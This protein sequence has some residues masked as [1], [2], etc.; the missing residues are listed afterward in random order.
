MPDMKISVGL[1]RK[2]CTNLV[3]LAFRKILINYIFNKISG[4]DF[5]LLVAVCLVYSH[6]S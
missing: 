3:V 1:R 4:N 5:F 2:S 6:F